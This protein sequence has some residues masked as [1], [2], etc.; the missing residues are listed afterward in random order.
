M[1]SNG[2]V[3]CA[4]R[5]CGDCGGDDD[6]CCGLCCGGFGEWLQEKQVVNGQ[7]PNEPM[8][9]LEC[10]CGIA[11]ETPKLALRML[12]VGVVVEAVVVELLLVVWRG[13]WLVMWK[14]V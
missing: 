3:W 8:G 12:P 5:V 14:E 9:H 7:C 1:E 4:G 13:W 2:D 6:V 11:C 10:V